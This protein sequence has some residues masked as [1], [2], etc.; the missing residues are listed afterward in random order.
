MLKNSILAPALIISIL[1]LASLGVFS[2]I[3]F[4]NTDKEVVVNEASFVKVIDWDTIKVS[5]GW[6][7]VNVRVL[8]IDTPEKFVLKK[9]YVECY[10]EEASDWA[11]VFFS[12]ASKVTLRTDKYSD[13]VDRYWRILRHVYVSWEDYSKKAIE[14]GV[15][16][17]MSGFLVDNS[18]ALIQ[19]QEL[20]K[21]TRV[22]VWGKCNGQFKPQ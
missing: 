14:A 12:W 13:D 5:Y 11:K 6:A 7:L 18:G 2:K 16:F 19:A 17:Y 9:G 20:A 15:G 22:W 3:E 4:W 21:G 1:F 8:W 10:G